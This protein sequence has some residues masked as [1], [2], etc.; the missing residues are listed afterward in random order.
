MNKQQKKLI[1]TL[2]T[3]TSILINRVDDHERAI[4]RTELAFTRLNEAKQALAHHQQKMIL[5]HVQEE[6]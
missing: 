4:A 6:K 5:E 3:K 1:E 2:A